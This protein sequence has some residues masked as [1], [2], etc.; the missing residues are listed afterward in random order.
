[1]VQRNRTVPLK[2]LVHFNKT[3]GIDSF[4]YEECRTVFAAGDWD[5][6]KKV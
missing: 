1:M 2:V 3:S 6:Y 5:F 4:S